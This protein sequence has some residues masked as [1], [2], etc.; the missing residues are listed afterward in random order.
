MKLSKS[1]WVLT[2]VVLVLGTSSCSSDDNAPSNDEKEQ[3][4]GSY[5]LTALNI[6]PAADVN[7]DGNTTSNVLTELPCATGNLTL[8]SDN[9]YSWTFVNVGVTFITGDLF[10]FSCSNPLSNKGLWEVKNGLLTLSDGANTVLFSV[11]ANG[12]LT[13]TIGDS[14]PGFN[15]NVYTKQ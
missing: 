1:I 2:L 3:A 11:G 4:V 13:N 5:Q 8:N 14:L 9:T 15:S 7:G 10:N 12:D 6:T